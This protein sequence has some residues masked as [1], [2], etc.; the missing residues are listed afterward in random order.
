MTEKWFRT[1]DSDSDFHRAWENTATNERLVVEEFEDG[2]WDI[3]HKDLVEN[4]DTAEEAVE[5]AQ[6]IMEKR[7]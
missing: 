6:D 7:P 2:T 1:E 5:R 4:F 3:F